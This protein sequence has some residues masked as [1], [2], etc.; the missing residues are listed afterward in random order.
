MRFVIVAERPSGMTGRSYLR[1]V[2]NGVPWTTPFEDE[3]AKMELC[4]ARRVLASVARCLDG[5]AI[6]AVGP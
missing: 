4:T 3:A 6:E 2:H 1:A 5:F